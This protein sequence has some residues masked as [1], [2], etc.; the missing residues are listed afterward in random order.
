MVSQ[1]RHS[2]TTHGPSDTWRHKFSECV[3]G[4]YLYHYVTVHIRAAG[5]HTINIVSPCYQSEYRVHE[6][7]TET[8]SNPCGKRRYKGRKYVELNNFF[9]NINWEVVSQQ[10]CGSGLYKVL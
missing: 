1:A 10:E 8:N 3:E 4:T 6:E 9:R 2:G 7:T 5:T